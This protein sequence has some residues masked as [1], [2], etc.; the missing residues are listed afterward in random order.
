MCGIGGIHGGSDHQN[1]VRQILSMQSNRGPDDQSEWRDSANVL[2]LCHNRLAILDLNERSNQPFLDSETGAA[3]V[4]NGEIYNFKELRAELERESIRFSTTSDTEVLLRGFLKWGTNLLPKL[5][6]M[7]AFAIWTPRNREL[8]ICRDRFGVKPLY[9]YHRDGQFAFASQARPL[10]KHFGCGVNFNYLARGMRWNL[11]DG[12]VN[13]SAYENIYQVPAG[14]Y[15]I[16]KDQ[17]L[18]FTQFYNLSERVALLTEKNRSISLED[19]KAESLALL[20]S[21]LQLRLRS[22]VPVTISLSGGLDSGLIAA[23]MRKEMMGPIRAFVFGDPEQS[24]SEARLARESARRNDITPEFVP[25]D[26]SQLVETFLETLMAQGAPFAHP[27]VLAQNLVFKHIHRAGYKVSLGGQGADE[28]FAGYRKFQLMMLKEQARNKS[29]GGLLSNGLGTALTMGS[30]IFSHNRYLHFF[31]RYVKNPSHPF[32]TAEEP[33]ESGLFSGFENTLRGRQIFD[34]A[35]GSLSTLLRYEDNNSMAHSVES[36][37]PF[38][39]YRLVEFGLSLPA[40][41]KVHGGFGKWVLRHA[42]EGLLPE[43]LI[44]TRN[45]KAFSA[46][47]NKWMKVGLSVYFK[48]Q[49]SKHESKLKNILSLET[50]EVLSDAKNFES[51]NHFALLSTIVWLGQEI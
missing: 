36:R 4:F 22:D 30:E 50:R 46:D 20:R 32:Q 6:G 23:L 5:N 24:D 7:F 31:K 15:S 19:A 14:H 38:L 21:G 35:G 45:K 13:D 8:F 48:D 27:S 33:R 3:I 40:S 37:M 51:A 49:Y 47:Y 42:A 10:A 26:E 9:Y 29:I 44:W 18:K 34:M 39:D 28:A 41:L 16:L 1:L 43:D 2:S 25:F 11:Y 17:D 12:L